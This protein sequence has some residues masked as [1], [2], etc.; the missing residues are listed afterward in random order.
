MRRLRRIVIIGNGGAGLSAVRSIRSRDPLSPISLVSRENCFA[1]SPVALTYYL[2]GDV[3]REHLFTTDE[4]FYRALGVELL[5][6]KKALEICPGESSVLIG[7]KG[8]EKIPYDGLLIATGASP[9][10]P[11][12]YA[13]GDV[14]TL[15]TLEDAERILSAAQHAK[16]AAILGGGLISMQVAQALHKRK[17]AVTLVVGSN[18]VL[19]RNTDQE[20]ARIIHRAMEERGLAV[21]YGVEAISCDRSSKTIR[22]FLS[23]GEMISADLVICG[24]GVTPNLLEGPLSTSEDMSVDEHMRTRLDGVYAAGDASLGKHVISGQWERVANWPNACHQGWV[25]GLNMAGVDARTDGLLNHHVTHLFGVQL[26]SMGIF[27]P[28]P[29]GRYD[30]LRWSD[31]GRRIYRKI[32]LKEGKLV[33]AI[34]VNDIRDA[35][36][37]RNLIDRKADLSEVLK[38]R[39]RDEL[40]MAA[41]M[42]FHFLAHPGREFE[43]QT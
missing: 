14:L 12:T 11:P 43:P 40:G 25:A 8:R 1:Y 35:G 10:L 32:V 39:F 17:L 33:G 31:E 24:K 27:D 36:L 20:A 26:V 41:L 4:A 15:R 7:D 6:G 29:D 13:D 38:K 21:R 22:L 2:A 37:I 5:L 30:V 19:S 18:Q 23:S 3:S 34:L 9:I 28:P 16:Q 42:R